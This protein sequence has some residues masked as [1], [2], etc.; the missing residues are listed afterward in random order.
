MKRQ[1]ITG[2]TAFLKKYAP[3]FCWCSAHD[4]FIMMEQVPE[5]EDVT[6]GSFKVML[7]NL[8]KNGYFIIKKASWQDYAHS[9]YFK[10]GYLYLR[11]N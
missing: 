8:K 7:I 6:E 1:K 9:R 5:L 11:V 4:L 3:D 10:T 2:V